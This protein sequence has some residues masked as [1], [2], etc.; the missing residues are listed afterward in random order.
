MYCFCKTNHFEKDALL[1]CLSLYLCA[2]VDYVTAT[3][4]LEDSSE[5]TK[6]SDSTSQ[7]IPNF[8]E[9]SL[10]TIVACL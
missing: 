3:T 8:D 5:E 1:I 2:L 9:V 6:Y 10:P 4:T 7:L